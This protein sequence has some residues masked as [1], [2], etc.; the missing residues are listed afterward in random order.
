[1]KHAELEFLGAPEHEP[2]NTKP[3]IPMTWEH[4]LEQ[5]LQENSVVKEVYEPIVYRALGWCEERP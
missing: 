3:R 2:Q 1:M 4:P 5:L